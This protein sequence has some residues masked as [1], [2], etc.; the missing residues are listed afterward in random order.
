MFR[1]GPNVT[2]ILRPLLAALALFCILTSDARTQSNKWYLCL[3][4]PELVHFVHESKAPEC[5]HPVA[6]I[7]HAFL[8]GGVNIGLRAKISDDGYVVQDGNHLVYLP[9][10]MTVLVLAQS[11]AGR[12]LVY[13]WNTHVLVLMIPSIV[14]PDG[15]KP[16]YAWQQFDSRFDAQQFAITQKITNFYYASPLPA[17]DGTEKPGNLDGPVPAQVPSGR[18]V[19]VRS[20][21]VTKIA[22][23]EEIDVLQVQ[24]GKFV[25]YVDYNDLRLIVPAQLNSESKYFVGGK[26]LGY[27]I[28]A[29]G[30]GRSISNMTE[31]SSEVGISA[32]IST[33]LANAVANYKQT[34]RSSETSK[35]E[36]PATMEIA[37]A[38]LGWFNEPTFSFFTAVW[39]GG[40]GLVVNRTDFD[41]M[42]IASCDGTRMQ[43]ILSKGNRDVIIEGPM[44][45][46]SEDDFDKFHDPLVNGG[47]T[48]DEA[49]F[50]LTF[51]AAAKR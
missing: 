50:V 31:K 21:N 37:V 14:Q 30:L 40:N 28:K 3:A 36:L 47:F 35:D 17:V 49:F 45:I 6:V 18:L 24:F 8:V 51:F 46:K 32:G 38:K 16:S 1:G 33:K 4:P 26:I 10:G 44:T 12:T 34:E 39:S 23:H 19:E 20:A 29:C 13:V 22:G 25:G 27:V 15:K 41:F 5:E 43:T 9:R 2:K 48:E 42:S 11:L 7:G